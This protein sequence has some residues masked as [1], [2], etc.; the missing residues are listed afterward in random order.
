[1]ESLIVTLL[2]YGIASGLIIFLVFKFIFW[3]FQIDPNV[4]IDRL[5]SLDERI[6][7]KLKE[8]IDDNE[9]DED[10][11]DLAEKEKQRLY[12]KRVLGVKN[13]NNQV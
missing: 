9:F 7:K 5:F 6:P 13:C 11:S 12:C 3:M 2:N 10:T 8:I 1:M 4:L